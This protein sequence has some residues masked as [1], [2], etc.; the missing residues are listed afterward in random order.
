MDLK[1]EIYLK[2]LQ[3]AIDEYSFETIKEYLDFDNHIRN[4]EN[5]YKAILLDTLVLEVK[6]ITVDG[7]ERSPGDYRL[8]VK[9]KN[10]DITIDVNNKHR[11]EDIVKEIKTKVI[12]TL[13]KG[14]DLKI[15]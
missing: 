4:I 1:D 10:K 3:E 8:R 12:L 5:L 11:K 13:V 14:K 7:V 9:V 15:L 2:R 6:D